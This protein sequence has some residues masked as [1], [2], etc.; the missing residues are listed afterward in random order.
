MTNW[1]LWVALANPALDGAAF[2]ASGSVLRQP[3]AVLDAQAP[4]SAPGYPAP[5]APAPVA[6]APVYPAPV[7]PAPVAPAPVY[8]AP[9]APEPVA[10]APVYPAPVAPAPVAPAAPA[11]VA[12]A[13]VYPAP[14]AP[15][16]VAPA[17]V[18]PAPAPVAPAPVAPAPVAPAPVAPA[19]VA[20]APMAPATPAPAAVAPAPVAVAPYPAAPAPVAVSPAPGD[21]VVIQP[22]PTLTDPFAAERPPAYRYEP[23]PPPAPPPRPRPFVGGYGGFNIRLSSASERMATFFGVRAG[24]LFGRR[25]S[26]GGAYYELRERFGEPM[27]D[28]NGFPML[29]GMGYGGLT[30]GVTLLLRERVELDVTSLIG[31]GGSCIAYV[32][33]SSADLPGGCVDHTNYFV[34]EPGANLYIKIARWARIGIE[35]GYRFVGNE[36]WRAPN[37]FPLSGGYGGLL[38]EFGWFKKPISSPP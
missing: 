26:V 31:G 28:V 19:P 7:A 8:P 25:F 5:V 24:L 12:P 27:R 17:P 6:P 2:A 15:A 16:P 11:P 18:A 35:G 37:D 9:V 33:S 1:W 21:P 20:P 38:F 30:V 22:P 14:V 13:P 10:P 23:A 36:D 3:F 32:P 29:L 34:I 4:P